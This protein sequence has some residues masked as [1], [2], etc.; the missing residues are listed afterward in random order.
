MALDKGV[1]PV[2]LLQHF[3]AVGY[4]LGFLE[5]PPGMRKRGKGSGGGGAA[6]AAGPGGVAAAVGGGGGLFG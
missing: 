4:S 2:D 1:D 3:A 6:A 5:L